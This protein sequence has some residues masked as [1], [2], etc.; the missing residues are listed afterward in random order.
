[1]RRLKEA[2][3]LVA[4]LRN[5]PGRFG[6][7]LAGWAALIDEALD[8][9]ERERQAREPIPQVYMTDGRPIFPAH[10]PDNALPFKGRATLFRQ[11]EQALGGGVGERTTFVLYGQRRTGKT[12]AL[13][14]LPRRLGAR[15]VPAFLDLQNMATAEHAASLLGSIAAGVTDEAYHHRQQRLPELDRKELGRDPYPAFQQWL[16]QVERALGR[17]TL[18]LCL[19]EFEKLEEAMREQRLDGRILDLLRTI[20][21]H[22]QQIAVLLSG[23]HQINELPAAWSGALINTTVLPVSFLDE[24]DAR[25]LIEQPVANYPRIYVPAAVDQIVHL[26]HCQPFLVQ[27]VCGRLVQRMNEAHRQPP[28]SCVEPAD[29]E[30]V[31]DDILTQPPSYFGDLWHNQTGSA[32]A[33]RVLERLVNAPGEALSSD[34]LR[35]LD[36]DGEALRDAIRTLHRREIITRTTDETGYRV[37]V[38]LIAAYV[39]RET[40]L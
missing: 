22:R 31:A 33:R 39:R 24:A 5:A 3:S 2:Q 34:T 4:D 32:L 10:R 9:A 27:L 12:S 25:D 18:L 26:T 15:I 16:D 30:A 11:L 29:V 1:V 19:D 20:I 8:E 21:Q 6:R 13:Y 35:T 7:A 37:T 17:S 36:Q 14:Q 23:T 38:P 40:R 28:A